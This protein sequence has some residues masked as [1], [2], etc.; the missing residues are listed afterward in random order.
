VDARIPG[1]VGAV[2]LTEDLGCVGAEHVL[3]RRQ[4]LEAQLVA[5]ADADKER[6]L[7]LAGVGDPLQEVDGDEGL[8]R[9][10]GQSKRGAPGLAGLL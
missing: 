10:C 1:V 5:V 7:E 2:V 3:E 6:A 8:A 9:A 4:A